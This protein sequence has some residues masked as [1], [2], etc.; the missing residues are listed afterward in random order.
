MTTL[1]RMYDDLMLKYQDPRTKDWLLVGNLGQL[2][3]ILGFYVYFCTKLGPRLMNNRKPFQLK[4]TIRFYNLAQICIS[5]YLVR[6]GLKCGWGT[7]YSFACE[8]VDY[9]DAPHAVRMRRAVWIY[10]MNKLVELLDTVFFILRKKYNQVTYLHLYHHTLMPV[11]AYVGVTFLPGGHGSLLGLI[12]SFIHVIMYTYYFLSSFGPEV[13]KYLWWKRHVT[14]LQ[15]VQFAIVF[16]HNFQVLF[17]KCD[18][19]KVFNVLLSIQAGYFLYLFGAFYVTA[20]IKNKP[21]KTVVE[22]DVV[23]PNGK[24]DN[25]AVR[26]GHTDSKTSNG[27]ANG[28]HHNTKSKMY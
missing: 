16:V 5:A 15:L 21:Q 4:R 12:N 11:A 9:T 6:E 3:L 2:V 7:T 20:Y 17:R 28:K 13:R 19:P 8:P 23:T 18:Y 26:N 22:A 27:V 14:K 1:I 25:G 24:M 10:Y